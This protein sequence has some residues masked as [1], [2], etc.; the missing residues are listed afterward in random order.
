M[1]F[2][3]GDTMDTWACRVYW[4]ITS[5]AQ[6][7]HGYYFIWQLS[8]VISLWLAA[9]YKTVTCSEQRVC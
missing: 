7:S 8:L 4:Q 6:T 2:S 1:I 9:L 5:G 3:V